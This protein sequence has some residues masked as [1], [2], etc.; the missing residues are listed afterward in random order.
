VTIDEEDIVEDIA[1][2]FFE[3]IVEVVP[4][5][6]QEEPVDEP[7]VENQCHLCRIQITTKDQFYN[8]IEVNH[9]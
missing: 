4:D 3:D 2:D 7:V 8:H 9:V 6:N 1:E 5:E